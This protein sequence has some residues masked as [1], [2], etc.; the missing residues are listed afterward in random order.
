MQGFQSAVVNEGLI[1]NEGNI[2]IFMMGRQCR[3]QLDHHQ[4][5]HDRGA[6]NCNRREWYRGAN[7]HQQRPHRGRRRRVCGHAIAARK[8]TI[9]NTGSMVGLVNLGGGNDVYNGASGQQTGAVLGGAGNDTIRTGIGNNTLDGGGGNDTLEGGLGVDNLIGG[10]GNDT[11]VLAN[12]ATDTI[13]DAGGADTITSTISRTLVNP[14]IENLIAPWDRQ[15]FRCRQ[16]GGQRHHRQ[17]WDERAQRLANNDILIGA[18]GKDTLVGGVGDDTF[19]FASTTHSLVAAPDVIT[20]FDDFGNDRID[21]SALFGPAM[22]Y[23]HSLAFTAAGQV[24]INDIAGADVLVEV[25]IGGSLAPDL[26][27][28]LAATA[29]ASMT[30]SDFVL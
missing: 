2:G 19:R 16:C 18:A 1:L 8:D 4:F 3:D 30:A 9:T 5:R 17:Q 6:E 13:T 27:I 28:R 7:P 10:V 11:Y 20:D 23:R 26:A 15:H 24:R 22:T 12:D 25:N 21:V 14:S 29:L